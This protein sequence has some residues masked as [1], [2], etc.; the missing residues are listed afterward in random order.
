MDSCC[1]G[2]TLKFKTQPGLIALW[3]QS[4]RVFGHYG[5]G[6]PLT[7]ANFSFMFGSSVYAAATPTP[8]SFLDGVLCNGL[9][10]NFDGAFEV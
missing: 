2:W 3:F 10:E 6:C 9:I 4:D 1:Y 8:A 5:S 7:T